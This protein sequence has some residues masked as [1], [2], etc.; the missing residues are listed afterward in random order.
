M[1]TPHSTSAPLALEASNVSKTFGGTAALTA[2][3]F[4][5]A[6]GEVHALLGENGSGK[7]TFIK[8]LSG[9]H[10]PDPGARIT[11]GGQPLDVGAAQSARTLGCRFV[12]QDLGLV[13]SE[14]IL[15]NLSFNSGYP[16]R[17]ATIRP[18]VAREH[19]RRCLAAVGLDID[20]RTPLGELSMAT[21]TAVAIARALR[22]DEATPPRLLVLD[23]PT[24]TL[25]A[26]EVQQLLAVVRNTAASGVGVVYVTH[27]I[28]EIFEIAGRVSVLR[29]GRR[30]ATRRVGELDHGT[31]VNLL[32]G[33]E[34]ELITPASEPRPAHAV[35]VLEVDN[36]TGPD[37]AGVSFRAYPGEIL[38]LA[39]ITGSGRESTLGAVFGAEER[40]GGTVR[41]SGRPV[42]PMRPDDAMAAGIAYMPADR[43]GRGS[44]MDLTVRENLTL[45]DLKPYWRRA[46]LRLRAEAVEVKAWSED[47]DIRPRGS[48]DRTLS[49]LSGGNQQKV[50]FAKWLRR[51][52]QVLLLDEPTQGVDIGAKALLHR[53]IVRAA[54]SGVAVVVSSSDADELV[55]LCHRV[56]I[57]RRGKL[58]FESKGTTL[59][60]SDITRNSLYDEGRRAS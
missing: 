25:P 41:V 53:Q 47:L 58:T 31:L 33:S 43:A 57:L 17:F 26:A 23:E 20:P 3:D 21:K 54:A 32:V 40:P 28:D 7:S 50:L 19:A 48:Y 52:P 12:H 10:R 29:D 16:T 24:A 30:V 34:I 45:T 13:D 49:S 56:L 6:P 2:F 8:I 37:L 46:L 27:R 38:G 4:T 44:V 9:Y 5:V 14:T 18:K 39:G 35:A 59:N 1:T 51:K 55:A 36:L 60:V 42:R 15:D 11:V 22:T